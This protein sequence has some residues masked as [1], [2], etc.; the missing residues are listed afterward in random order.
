MGRR[1]DVIADEYMQRAARRQR[2]LAGVAIVFY[3]AIVV[4]CLTVESTAPAVVGIGCTL[5]AAVFRYLRLSE[6]ID[7][8]DRHTRHLN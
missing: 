1:S 5:F 2:S 3:A 6:I 8:D 4:L 7:R